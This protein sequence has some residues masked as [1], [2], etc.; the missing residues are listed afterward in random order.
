MYDCVRKSNLRA[1]YIKHTVQYREGIKNE[2]ISFA[3]T[4][5][6]G[7]WLYQTHGISILS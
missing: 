6:L 7:T 4:G 3:I 5:I 2:K 1:N